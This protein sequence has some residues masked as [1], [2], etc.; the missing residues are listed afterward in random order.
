MRKTCNYWLVLIVVFALQACNAPTSGGAGYDPGRD[1]AADLAAAVQE[2]SASDRRILVEVGGEWCHW[3]H[4]LEK[5][6]KNH[7]ELRELL[8]DNFVVV[9]VNF[10]PE[11]E[12][13]AFL[14]R[15]PVFKGYPHIMILDSDGTHLHSQ[16]TG[17]L[18]KGEGYD[19]A[20]MKAFLE[21]WSR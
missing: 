17:Q 10:S 18:E 21:K 13:E 6:F 1:P 12:N 19:P 14:S 20:A 3:C 5:F 16:D 2:A 4:I 9:K 8:E 11:N 7:D 15:F